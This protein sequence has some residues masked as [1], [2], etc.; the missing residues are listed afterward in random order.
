M[1]SAS[2]SRKPVNCWLRRRLGPLDHDVVA[3]TERTEGWA[4]GLRLA[5]GDTEAGGGSLLHRF[6][7]RS[8]LVAAY[9][10]DEVL[11]QIPFEETRFFSIPPCSIA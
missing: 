9:F 1:T 11:G 4:V 2:A 7:R 6:R 3:L 10:N 5:A 8:D